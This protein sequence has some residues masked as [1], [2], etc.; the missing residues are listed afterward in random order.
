[1]CPL[2]FAYSSV[3]TYSRPH[4][5]PPSG[6]LEMTNPP[7]SPPS[8]DQPLPMVVPVPQIIQ[9][10]P[11]QPE[12]ASGVAVASMVLGIIG[13]AGGCCTFGVPSIIAVILGHVGLR[14]TRKPGVGGRGMA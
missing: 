7:S 11:M 12:H 2:W 4:P 13:L 9:V 3:I 8:G 10:Q 6:R 5:R 14:S 1:M